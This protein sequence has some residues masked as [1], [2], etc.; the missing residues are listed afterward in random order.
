MCGVF[1]EFFFKKNFRK[2]CQWIQEFLF[3]QTQQIINP[4]HRGSKRIDEVIT[5][6][7]NSIV[8]S[9]LVNAYTIRQRYIYLCKCCS[10]D[11]TTYLKFCP[12]S[13]TIREAFS[14]VSVLNFL[15]Y[16]CGYRLHW[17]FLLEAPHFRGKIYFLHSL[18]VV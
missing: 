6:D 10:H 17:D 16:D 9:I 1:I 2:A 14:Y 3:G 7:G 12:R 13:N 18:V 4:Y 15:Y 8:L 11:K 5:R